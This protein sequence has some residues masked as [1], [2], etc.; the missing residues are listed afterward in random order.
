MK[1]GCKAKK[2]FTLIEVLASLVILGVGITAALAGLS[3]IAK[4]EVRAREVETMHRLAMDKLNELR[5][6]TDTFAAPDS[7]DFTDRDLVDYAWNLEVE[8]TGIENLNAV[9]VIVE[10]R[11]RAQGSPRAAATSLVFQAPENAQEG[12]GF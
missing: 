3:A 8:A 4:S 2:G 10:R 11:S 9:T 5:A 7:G 6:V 1:R 12:A